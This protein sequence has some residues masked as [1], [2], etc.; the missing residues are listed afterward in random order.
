[1]CVAKTGLAMAGDLYY[2]SAS[3]SIR[4]LLVSINYLDRIRLSIAAY[5]V[6]G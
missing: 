6:F 2:K 1:M 5:A 3:S 4:T